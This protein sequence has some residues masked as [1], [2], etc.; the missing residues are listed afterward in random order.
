MAMTTRR[1]FLERFMLVASGLFL[2]VFR[3]AHAASQPWPGIIYTSSHPG[4]WS[5]KAGSHVPLVK[6]SGREVT[7][8]TPHPMVADHYIVR[9]TLVLNDGTVAGSKTFSPAKDTIATSTMSL[10]SEYRGAIYVTSFCN[11]HDLWMAES[12][13]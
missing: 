11:L 7:V 10:P 6:V 3:N 8:T 4:M 12:T 5:E 2:G 9:H 1:R 13:V